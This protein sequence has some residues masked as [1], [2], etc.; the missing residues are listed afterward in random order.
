MTPNQLKE[1]SFK[2]HVLY[3]EDDDSLRLSTQKLLAQFFS[4]VDIAVDGQEGI[5]KYREYSYDLVISDINM[6]RLDGIELARLIKEDNPEQPIIITSAY[7][8]SHYLIDLIEV[9]VD[10]FV[11]KPIDL[12]KLIDA[13]IYICGYIELQ[14]SRKNAFD[15][16]RILEHEVERLKAK[17]PLEKAHLDKDDELKLEALE[18]RA[19]KTIFDFQMENN[20]ELLDKNYLMNSFK[21]YYEIVRKGK[22]HL[23]IINAV[24]DITDY[25]D[26][27]DIVELKKDF[28]PLE[29]LIH[30]MVSVRISNFDKSE[31]DLLTELVI[32]T[33]KTPE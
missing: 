33:I 22:T 20:I 14:N 5:E 21:K 2:Y 15:Y 4:H 31:Q 25:I 30:L 18:H 10:K 8:D 12:Q 28:I 29:N 19:M 16:V 6:P 23:G 24:L 1:I 27:T 32:K 7:N 13:F 11:Q 17:L 3:I 26:R 9:G